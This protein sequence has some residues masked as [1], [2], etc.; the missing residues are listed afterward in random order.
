MLLSITY[1]FRD[2]FRDEFMY[3]KKI[4][5]SYMNTGV[6]KVPD[7]FGVLRFQMLARAAGAGGLSRCCSACSRRRPP[8]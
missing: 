7:N 3:M 5:K 4:A 6:T 1:E 2:E 8:L